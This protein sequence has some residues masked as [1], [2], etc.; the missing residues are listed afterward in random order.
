MKKLTSLHDRIAEQLDDVLNG[1]KVIAEWM[2]LGKKNAVFKDHGNGVDNYRPISCLPF[3]W[4]LSTGGVV[5]E[6]TYN[7]L[8]KNN[9]LPEEQRG[10]R[11]GS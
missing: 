7:F 6:S 9:F 11:K 2:T 8:I 10:C 4:K 1:K 3:M 5:S